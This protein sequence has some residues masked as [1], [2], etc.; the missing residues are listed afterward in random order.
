MDAIAHYQF[1]TWLKT[2]HWTFD[3]LNSVHLFFFQNLEPWFPNEMKNF[4]SSEKKTLDRSW[5]FFF[6]PKS[7]HPLSLVQE[8]LNPPNATIVSPF[9]GGFWFT[10]SN[11]GLLL[12]KFLQVNLSFCDILKLFFFFL[13]LSLS[14]IFYLFFWLF[15]FHLFSQFLTS[16]FYYWS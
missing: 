7:F 12:A 13:L 15:S 9:H 6:L 14:N 11:F 4:L 2:S 5:Y 1:I 16:S 8:W 10:D 3:N